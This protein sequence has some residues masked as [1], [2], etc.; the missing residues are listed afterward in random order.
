MNPNEV[1]KENIED[2]KKQGK[3]VYEDE[4]IA[5]SWDPDICI[6][7]GECFKTAPGVFKPQERP[8]IQLE[9]ES[10]EKTVEAV[11]KCP[12]GAIKYCLKKDGKKI[13]K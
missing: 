1:M 10:L 6:H 13:C 8:W 7:A 2:L 4:N 9:G 3:K 11:E 5:I 12:S